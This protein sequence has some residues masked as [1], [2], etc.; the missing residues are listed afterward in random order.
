MVLLIAAVFVAPRQGHRNLPFLG[1]RKPH[2]AGIGDPGIL[3]ISV[4]GHVLG[5][6]VGRVLGEDLYVVIDIVRLAVPNLEAD[7]EQ[8]F[9]GRLRDDFTKAERLR[10]LLIGVDRCKC[11]L[12]DWSPLGVL[13]WSGSGNKCLLWQ[14]L[15]QIKSQRIH[16]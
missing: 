2:V 6:L 9:P 13:Y 16:D 10:S 4:Y 11:Y 8:D 15:Q 12:G 5:I 1:D 14:G 3:M 7:I